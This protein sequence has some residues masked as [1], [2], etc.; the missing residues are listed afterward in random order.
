[1]IRVILSEILTT[2]S[3]SDRTRGEK[4]REI[5]L[6]EKGDAGEGLMEIRDDAMNTG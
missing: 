2:G 4:N 1:M 6:G 5:E 3:E